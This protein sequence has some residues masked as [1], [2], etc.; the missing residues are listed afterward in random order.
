MKY[1]QRCGSELTEQTETK[2]V[3][4]AQRCGY[5]QYKNPKAAV[6][7][8]LYTDDDK[9]VLTRRAFEPFAGEMDI[10]GGFLDRGENFEEALS[11]ELQEE[12]GCSVDELHDLRYLTS[13]HTWYPWMGE[14]ESVTSVVFLAKIDDATKLTPTDDV[15]E[16]VM[17]DSN[18]ASE[19]EFH[20]ASGIWRV[21]DAAVRQL[22]HEKNPTE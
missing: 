10:I 14:D 20:G 18:T 1:C 17:Y 21:V 13:F 5:V 6:G 7:V 12:T 15:A 22:H 4:A 2:N 11:R 9:L 3:C 19:A 16:F 8:V